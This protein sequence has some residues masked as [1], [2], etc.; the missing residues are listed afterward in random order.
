MRELIYITAQSDAEEHLKINEGPGIRVKTYKNQ[1]NNK[2][3]NLF[4]VD[5]EDKVLL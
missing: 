5:Q 2:F 4:Q 3:I 1:L